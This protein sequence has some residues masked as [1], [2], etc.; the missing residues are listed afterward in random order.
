MI[1][2]SKTSTIFTILCSLLVSVA[3]TSV[4]AASLRT[5]KRATTCNG[6]S[7][8][9]DRLYS[10]VTFAGA[11]NSYA[12]VHSGTTLASNQNASITSQLNA[13]IRMLQS[14]AHKSSNSSVTGAGIDLCHTECSLFQGG[15]IEYWLSQVKSWVDANPTEVV[16]LLIVNS[17][18]LPASQYAQAFQSTGLASK[19]YT[20]SSGVLTKQQWPTLGSM[21]D[22]GKTVVGFLTSGT[23][24]STVPYLLDEFSNIWETPYDQ[25]SV[26]FNCSIDRIGS[27]VKSTSQN[28]MYLSNQ[29]RDLSLFGGDQITTPDVANIG[30][31][32][33]EATTLSSS[34]TCASEHG[35]YPN[36]ILT[37][38]STVPDYDFPRAVAQMNGVSYTAPAQSSNSNGLSS[39]SSRTTSSFSSSIALSFIALSSALVYFIL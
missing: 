36:F 16:T 30:S 13:G 33:S 23:D 32:N 9:C 27:N 11:H 18:T 38:Y 26:P 24:T 15:T 22:S 28:L 17:D 6:S 2:N 4:H 35:S 29:F 7:Q 37:D 5:A 14:Q 39:G 31:T 1:S 3:L 10:N 19:M 20:P 21:V 12:I 34:D 25:T 8:L